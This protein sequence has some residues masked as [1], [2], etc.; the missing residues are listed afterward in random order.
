MEI[1]MEN[2]VKIVGLRIKNLRTEKKL[3][4]EKLAEMSGL[5]STYIGQLE[6]GEKNPTLLSLLK[7]AGALN[8]A[9]ETL[10]ADLGKDYNA[11][12]TAADKAF[13]L[14]ST[15]NKN[16]SEMLFSLLNQ[17]EEYKRAK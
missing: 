8:I 11:E 9:P 6:R 10:V 7:I 1:I 14:F 2:A 3:S 4:Q 13:D 17:I 12:P 5:H 15:L 16:D